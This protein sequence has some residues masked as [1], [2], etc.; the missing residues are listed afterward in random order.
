MSIKNI[1]ASTLRETLAKQSMKLNAS[2]EVAVLKLTAVLNLNDLTAL[3]LL[4]EIHMIYVELR[5]RRSLLAWLWGSRSELDMALRVIVCDKRFHP[6]RVANIEKQEA[7]KDKNYVV[8][9]A[10]VDIARIRHLQTTL[11]NKQADY[12]KLESQNKKLE[13][14]IKNKDKALD[15]SRKVI[16]S[17]RIEIENLK[18]ANKL[19]EASNRRLQNQDVPV[20]YVSSDTGSDSDNSFRY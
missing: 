6:E 12:K 2:D 8:A 13:S 18:R 4:G 11:D 14:I 17:Q 3:E 16:V 20:S 5:S 1:L 10:S 7:G 19:L 9:H 15:K